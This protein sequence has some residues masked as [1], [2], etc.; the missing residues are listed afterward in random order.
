MD[1]RHIHTKG[2]AS[3][4]VGM[5]THRCKSCGTT[6]GFPTKRCKMVYRYCTY[7]QLDIGELTYDDSD[8]GIYMDA[9][10]GDSTSAGGLIKRLRLV[11]RAAAWGHPRDGA[12][13]V[14]VT[15][16]LQ[17]MVDDGTGD[18]L[19]INSKTF[20]PL[21]VLGDPYPKGRKQLTICTRYGDRYCERY[22]MQGKGN[23]LKKSLKILPPFDP[24][25]FI[26]YAT[27]GHRSDPRCQ[28]NVTEKIQ[29]RVDDAGGRYLGIPG[30]E[31][32]ANWFGDPY[33]GG[34]KTLIIDYEMGGWLGD[35]TVPEAHG[36][37][38]EPLTIIAPMV[39]PQL[40]IKYARF[41][42]LKP[43]KEQSLLK[44]ARP[45]FVDDKSIDSDTLSLILQK[46][47]DYCEGESLEIKTED[48]MIE[49]VGTDPCPGLAK[50]FYI[51]YT[52]REHAGKA[53][54]QCDTAGHLIETLSL[55]TPAYKE[56][57]ERSR[58]LKGQNMLVAPGVCLKSAGFG[59]PSMDSAKGLYDITSILQRRLDNN[60]GKLLHV[61]RSEDLEKSFGN[62]CRGVFKNLFVRY[63]MPM[64][65]Q[66]LEVEGVDRRLQA[67]VR[68]GWP[69]EL[70]VSPPPVD[71]P[72]K[73]KGG[74]GWSTRWKGDFDVNALHAS[75]HEIAMA[76]KRKIEAAHKALQLKIAM[77]KRKDREAAL[78]R[79][80]KLLL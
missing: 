75:R 10:P 72:L 16:I 70:T 54:I 32:V 21:D 62:P 30:D 7:C 66:T 41:G 36:H 48:N 2:N 39:T 3:K 46:R 43:L 9:K 35:V 38:L 6:M 53:K 52:L 50:V 56:G 8:E 59:H 67:T 63:Q 77:Q 76:K 34:R 27:Y 11:I 22:V 20:K 49:I 47:A 18:S 4:Y 45:K 24:W 31:D 60:K 26:I 37:V 13:S 51:E 12:K 23:R 61:P 64:W 74:Q 14:D 17:K 28:Y 55:K 5:E 73:T 79:K 68:L 1:L 15:D 19:I 69:G 58:L 44:G 40:K 78:A 29:A 33:P 42:M 25:L 80:G 71:V 57:G 65:M